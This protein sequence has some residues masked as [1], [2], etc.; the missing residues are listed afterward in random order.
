MVKWVG[1]S[2][3]SAFFASLECC[4]CINLS[5]SHDDVIEDDEEAKDCPFMLTIPNPLSLN[6]SATH[7]NHNSNKLVPP[8]ET[9]EQLNS[10]QT[11]NSNSNS[12]IQN[13][14]INSQKH[15]QERWI[16]NLAGSIY[17]KTSK[18]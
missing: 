6:D 11:P 10:T 5:T 17:T 7:C 1:S 18:K 16:V 8:T 12:K 13:H 3:A 4:S 14:Q 15:L 9:G 2:L